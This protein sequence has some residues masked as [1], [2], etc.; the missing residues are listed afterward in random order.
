MIHQ[1]YIKDFAIINEISLPFNKGL[2]VITGETGA[3]KSLL[4]KSLAITLGAKTDKTD[5]RSGQEQAVVEAELS[6]GGPEKIFRRLIN[7][8]G[9]TRSFIDDKP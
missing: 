4:L 1:L 5:V 6:V 3:G 9:R 2:T 7:K 8:N